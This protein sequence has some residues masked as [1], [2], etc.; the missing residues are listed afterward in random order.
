MKA[1]DIKLLLLYH[2]WVLLK[3]FE[4]FD[5]ALAEK[6]DGKK[7]E[8]LDIDFKVTSV[9]NRSMSVGRDSLAKKTKSR[10]SF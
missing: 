7:G 5:T 1:A 3:E 10:R 2:E 6:L 8:K 9:L 4:K